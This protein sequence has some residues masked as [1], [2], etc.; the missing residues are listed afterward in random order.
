MLESGFN[1]SR[2][3]ATGGG[4]GTRFLSAWWQKAILIIVGCF[5]TLSVGLLATLSV[6]V[7]ILG[8]HAFVSPT[9]SM[10]PTICINERFF[11]SMDAYRATPPAR[12]D[13]IMFRYHG[14]STLYVKRV[15]A[16]AGDRVS[17]GTANAVLINGKPLP[18]SKTCGKPDS[19]DASPSEG[20]PFTTIVV[21]KD[22]FSY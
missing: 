4:T 10:C 2:I 22:A 18:S 3:T 21:P 5:L 20:P 19:Q 6:A 11:A 1:P 15:V 7:S 16:V 9:N 14:D 17:P 12:G 13:I 8:L